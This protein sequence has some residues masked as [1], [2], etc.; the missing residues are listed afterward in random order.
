MTSVAEK[1]QTDTW[2][3]EDAIV[4]EFTRIMHEWG[5][6]PFRCGQVTLPTREEALQHLLTSRYSDHCIKALGACEPLSR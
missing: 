4:S 2:A 3:T 5:F 1:D 6:K